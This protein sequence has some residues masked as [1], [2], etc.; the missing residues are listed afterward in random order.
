M[1]TYL[2][3]IGAQKAGT[4]SL[5]HYLA[6]QPRVSVTP[7]ELNFFSDDRVWAKGFDWYREQITDPAKPDAVVVGE[8]S[9]SYTMRLGYPESATRIAATVPDARLVY[10]L[11]DPIER[12]RSAYQHALAAGWERRPMSEALLA[13]ETYLDPSRYAAQLDRYATL[14]P[15]D[16]L[17]LVESAELRRDRAA[18]VARVLGFAGV[19]EAPVPMPDTEMNVTAARR[20]PRRWAVRVGDTVIRRDWADRV[21]H[22][23]VRQRERES[24]LLTRPFRND[25]TVLP[26][27][28]RA[29]LVRRL[30]PDVD[31]LRDWLGHDFHGWGM[32]A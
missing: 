8:T 30:R 4:Q 29:E 27:D 9:P 13:D 18:V 17:L 23:L 6:A 2:L 32:L 16:Q 28:L 11:R 19:D 7:R 20:V 10:L 5:A 12:M 31:A 26:D 24:R 21:P 25:E 1:T 14:I 3:I 15:R 22:W